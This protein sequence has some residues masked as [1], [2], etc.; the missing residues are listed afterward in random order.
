MSSVLLK[1]WEVADSG[2]HKRVA[3]LPKKTL[4]IVRDKQETTGSVLN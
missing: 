3:K 2:Q 4:L 1:A